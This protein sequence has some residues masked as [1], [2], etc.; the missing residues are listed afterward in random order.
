MS[1]TAD[2]LD[3]L[4]HALGVA[5]ERKRKLWGFR[6]YF[7]TTPTDPSFARLVEAGF[8]KLRGSINDG[9]DAVFGATH[10]GCRAVGMT[11]A[12]IEKSRCLS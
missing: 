5:P 10:E 12:E 7:V 11:D 6:N 1:I 8:A 3:N 4:R 9:G 2:D